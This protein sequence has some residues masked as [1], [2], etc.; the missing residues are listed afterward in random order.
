VS[1]AQRKLDEV[2]DRVNVLIQ[3]RQITAEA[4]GGVCDF[5]SGE[6]PFVAFELSSPLDAVFYVWGD[7]GESASVSHVDDGAWYTC[8]GCAP[9]VR[10]RDVEGLIARGVG[11]I[12][13]SKPFVREGMRAH[14]TEVMRR[15]PREV[16]S[17]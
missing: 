7:E 16:G 11:D 4:A 17:A 14:Y 3:A 5:C 6:G 13:M 9:L 2:V 8:P 1:D 12:D 10:A 15:E